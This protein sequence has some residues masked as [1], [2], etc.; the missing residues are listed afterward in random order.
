[1]AT[2]T[3]PARHQQIPPLPVLA[4]PE[5]AVCCPPLRTAVLEL[6]D[7]AVQRRPRRPGPAAP[8]QPAGQ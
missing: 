5:E 7:A 6:T 8:A 4:L 1:M 2:T 3:Q